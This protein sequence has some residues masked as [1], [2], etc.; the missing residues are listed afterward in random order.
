M[1]AI[2]FLIE[3][4]C[5]IQLHLCVFFSKSS[6]IRECLKLDPDHKD[7][8]S[9]YKKVKKLAKQISSVHELINEQ[10]WD[11]CISKVDQMLKTEPE[12]FAFV[13]KA[14]SHKCHCYAKVGLQRHDLL[15]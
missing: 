14:N 4:R 11:D 15:I 8:F 1:S 13:H 9:H 3:T 2:V 6:E 12:L 7:C 10:K 5:F